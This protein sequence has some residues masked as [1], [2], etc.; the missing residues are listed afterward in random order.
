[1]SIFFTDKNKTIKQLFE[2][3]MTCNSRILFYMAFEFNLTKENKP[4]QRNESYSL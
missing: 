3:V 4:L 1:M 2:A